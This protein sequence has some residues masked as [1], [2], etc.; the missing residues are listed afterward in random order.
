MTLSNRYTP[1]DEINKRILKLQRSLVQNDLDGALILHKTDL[2][3][4]SGNI[5]QAHLFVPVSGDP[6]LMVRK[7][8][9]RALQESAIKTIVSITSPGQISAILQRNGYT[10]IK[11]LGL[12]LDV[13]PVNLFFR[14]QQLF[15]ETNLVD[16]SQALRM[17]RA[18]KSD[19]ELHLIRKAARLSDQVFGYVP[20]VLKEGMTEIELAGK[21][22]SFARKLGHQGII[23]MRMWGNE[24]FYGHLM[25]GPSAA[26]PSYLASPTGGSGISPAIAQ[27]PGDKP[28]QGHEPV[29]IDY[30]FVFQ[31]YIADSTRIFALKGLPDELHKA[32][33]AMLELQTLLKKMTLPGTTAEA[34]YRTACDWSAESGYRDYFMGGDEERVRFVGHGVGLELDEYPF[35]AEGQQTKLCEGMTIALE[36]K[37]IFP[38]KGVVGIE[39]TH[40]MTATGLEQLPRFDEGIIVV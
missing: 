25:S 14:Y 37:L 4:F 32:H 10:R 35:L 38:G 27:G 7:S 9:P 5:Q 13:L 26:T 34:I 1:E 17:F 18:V 20:E 23:R 16:I 30:V 19:Y 40:V 12:E 15:P 2:F 31:G 21:I 24:L 39:N 29:L 6:I 28:I 8:Y 36:P 3:Y 33:A 22:E 11:R